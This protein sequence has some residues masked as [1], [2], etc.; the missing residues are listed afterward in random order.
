MFKRTSRQRGLF[1]AESVVSEGVRRRLKISWA[2]GFQAKVLPV[3]LDAEEEFAALY[4]D[5]TGRPCSSVA[6]LLG[7]C[8]LQEMLDL[9]DQ[10]ALDS[11]AF[12]VRWQHALGM[13]PEDAYLSRRSLVEFR[14][15]QVSKDPEMKNLRRVFELVG[16]AAISELKLS[17][18]EQRVDS[19]LITSNIFTRGRVDL[20]RKTLVHFFDWLTREHPALLE[21]LSASTREWYAQTEESG[22]FGKLDKEKAKQEA[23]TLAE[24]LYEV[25]RAF[26][27]HEE[28]KKAESYQLVARL[29]AEH[30]EI[31]GGDDKGGGGGGGPGNATKTKVVLRKKVEA[32]GSSLQSPFDPDAGYSY[33]GPGYLA[34]VAETCRNDGVE[35]ITDY[36]LGAAGETDRGKDIEVIDRLGEAKRQPAVLYADGGYPTGQGLID[37][38]QRGTEIVAPMTGGSLPENTVGR[39]SFEFDAVTGDCTRCPAGNAPLRH[40]TRT[41]GRNHPPTLHAYFDGEKCR[42]CPTEPRCVVRTPN[43]GKAGN[44]H[45]EVGAHLIARDKRLAAQRDDA[46]WDRYKIR[47]GIEATISELKRSHGFGRLRVRR[48]PRVLFAVSLKVMACNVKRW[49]RAAVKLEKAAAAAQSVAKVAIS[50]CEALRSVSAFW[51]PRTFFQPLMSAA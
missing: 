21:R 48:R 37:A 51:R 34:H 9:D 4:S 42:A 44:M 29:F 45:L 33:K 25:V 15:R 24:R 6:R 3:L 10:S 39:E 19:T 40:N 22:W 50:A 7:I 2:E 18:K 32:P 20:F 49:L 36:A 11:V 8:V 38:E 43:N 12:D 47:A 46:W 17:T 16:E 23:V 30:C 28:V 35:I 26:A 27:E 31:Q 1:E 41:T 13:E 14:S 5:E